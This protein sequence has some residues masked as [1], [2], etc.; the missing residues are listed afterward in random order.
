MEYPKEVICPELKSIIKS[1][2]YEITK[3]TEFG[4]DAQDGDG[5]EIIF[6]NQT[7]KMEKI[8]HVIRMQ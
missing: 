7:I 6:I 8:K 3:N 2:H 4:Y 5:L 1:N